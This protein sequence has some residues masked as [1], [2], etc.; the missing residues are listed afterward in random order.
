[1]KDS[2]ISK[3]YKRQTPEGNPKWLV[4]FNN[5]EQV[6]ILQKSMQIP[7]YLWLWVTPSWWKDNEAQQVWGSYY[8]CLKSYEGDII[9]PA[10]VEAFERLKLLKTAS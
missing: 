8:S 10:V 1:M 5:G 3:V 4:L 2:R 9:P 7:M 6:F